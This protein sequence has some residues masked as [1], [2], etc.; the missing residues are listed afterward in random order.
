MDTY[1]EHLN[2]RNTQIEICQVSEDQ[3]HAKEKPNGQ[4]S[5]HVNP[6]GHLDGLSS[7][8]ERCSTSE[9]LGHDCGKDEMPCCEDY[10]VLWAVS[11]R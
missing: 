9:R 11:V 8:K 5:S 3:T 6:S 7:I 10:R 2:E 4:D 1:L